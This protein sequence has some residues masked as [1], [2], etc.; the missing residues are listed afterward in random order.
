M[1]NPI[2]EKEILYGLA[3]SY[4]SWQDSCCM[5]GVTKRS[6]SSGMWPRV[7]REV[8]GIG[9]LAREEGEEG[10]EGKVVGQLVFMP[11]RYARRIGLPSSP[12]NE[13]ID[14]TLVIGCFFVLKDY[15]NRGI[16]SGMIAKALEFCREHGFT[17]LEACVDSRPPNIS[18]INTS[19]YPFRKFGF[20]IDD[21]REG[22]EFNPE[23]RIC[24]LDL[25]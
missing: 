11:K 23:M 15:A 21:S 9:F 3:D 8:G 5:W 13:G 6:Y 17:R 10:E 14:T 7:F 16:G 18:G 19:F 24:F 4:H 1:I 2:T 20:T 22:W 25:G 12:V